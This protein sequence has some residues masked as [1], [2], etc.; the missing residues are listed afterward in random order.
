VAGLGR[1]KRVNVLFKTSEA[2]KVLFPW[3]GGF[4][5][6]KRVKVLFKKAL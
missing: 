4:G 3:L 6:D 1:D 2:K 5:R